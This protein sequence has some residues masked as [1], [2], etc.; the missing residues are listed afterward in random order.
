M[1]FSYF[2][3]SLTQQRE[4][5]KTNRFDNLTLFPWRYMFDQGHN[6]PG[7]YPEN[8][9]IYALFRPLCHRITQ[10]YIIQSEMCALL[11]LPNGIMRPYYIQSF[12]MCIFFSSFSL[13]IHSHKSQLLPMCHCI[14]RATLTHDSRNT[15]VNITYFVCRTLLNL[16]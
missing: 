6:L 13:S 4:R 8:H 9:G 15:N 10:L 16:N 3:S 14:A 2:D 5:E 7:V 12:I 1:E 11:L